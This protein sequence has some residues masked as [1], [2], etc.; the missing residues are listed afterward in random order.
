MRRLRLHPTAV[1][2]V[3]LNHRSSSWVPLP[4]AVVL[5]SPLLRPRLSDSQQLEAVSR[6]RWAGTTSVEPSDPASAAF[7]QQGLGRNAIDRYWLALHRDGPEAALIGLRSDFRKHFSSFFLRGDPVTAVECRAL[8]ATFCVGVGEP[9]SSETLTSSALLLLVLFSESGDLQMLRSWFAIIVLCTASGESATAAHSSAAAHDEAASRKQTAVRVTSAATS[10]QLNKP[11]PLLTL[12]VDHFNVYLAGVLRGDSFTEDEIVTVVDQFMRQRSVSPD[13]TTFL[14]RAEAALRLGNDPLPLWRQAAPYCPGGSQFEATRSALSGP[15]AERGAEHEDGRRPAAAPPTTAGAGEP[16]Q[17]RIALMIAK[18]VDFFT[19]LVRGHYAAATSLEVLR[20]LDVLTGKP[21]ALVESAGP[22][23]QITSRANDSLSAGEH[24][25]LAAAGEPIAAGTATATGSASRAPW[26][27]VAQKTRQPLWGLFYHVARSEAVPIVVEVMDRLFQVWDDARDARRISPSV[28]LDVVS[29]AIEHGELDAVRWLRAVA[30]T[31]CGWAPEVV[32]QMQS[33]VL[34]AAVVLAATACGNLTVALAE[35]E[36][37][38]ADQ[39]AL[40]SLVGRSTSPTAV[41]ICVPRSPSTNM[42]PSSGQHDDS[43]PSNNNIYLYRILAPSLPAVSLAQA[44]AKR[45]AAATDQAYVFLLRLAQQ[46]TPPLSAP[47]VDA[48]VGQNSP[49]RPRRISSI[50]LDVV[51]ASCA[52][53]HE[54]ARA[55]DTIELYHE[56]PF[57]CNPSEATFTLLLAACR[58]GDDLVEKQQTVLNAM[59]RFGIH[60]SPAVVTTLLMHSL[61]CDSL[62][63]AMHCVDVIDYAA[64]QGPGH[65]LSVPAS[66]K[67]AAGVH[68]L[69]VQLRSIPDF[70]A[71]IHNLALRLDAIGDR[72]SLS[73]L[74]LRGLLPT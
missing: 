42:S 70:A 61:A 16:A 12:T 66:A 27:D 31:R 35:L 18:L 71:A 36:H 29:R 60:V 47:G 10:D 15:S 6:R 2:A 8:V 62:P 4:S 11:R 45:G 14:C 22:P 63:G 51:V 28:F 7:E 33:M 26:L 64:G 56:A 53:L 44:L 68:P 25:S 74:R 17:L 48:V 58:R 57:Q 52:L 13:L 40:T 59:K 32:A 20:I 54:E 5:R 50:S 37:L 24:D 69:V 3:E 9:S 39:A 41:N 72:A 46:P 34:P 49:R 38:P 67:G 73:R 55:V 19:A 65:G 23:L 30:V 1:A 43:S 21:A